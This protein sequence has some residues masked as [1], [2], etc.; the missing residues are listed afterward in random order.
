MSRTTF[1]ILIGIADFALALICVW[2]ALPGLAIG[3][4]LGAGGL[5]LATA[6]LLPGVSEPPR[7]R[8]PYCNG[9]GL[10]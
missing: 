3:V 1:F 4:C 8:C 2:A 10:A 7:Q 9:T 6:L 5:S